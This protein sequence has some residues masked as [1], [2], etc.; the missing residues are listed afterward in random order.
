MADVSEYPRDLIGYADRPVDPRWPGEAKLAIQI[1]INYEEG[2]ENSVLHG[3]TASEAMLAEDP[4][5]PFLGARNIS[6][7]SQYEYGSRAGF[8]R[9]HRMLTERNLP[10]T[11][12]GITT[13]LAKN[14]VA[15][16]AMKSAG[17]EIA[18]HGLKWINY[19]HMPEAEERAQIAESIRLHEEVVGEPPRGWYT[20]R[21]SENTRRLL[22]ELGDF[23]Y[24]SDSFADDLPYWTTENGEP[25][26][27]VPYALDSNDVRYLNGFGLQ[28]PD[29]STYLIRACDLLRREGSVAPKMMS[30]GL[31]CRIA[32]RP[33]RA[34][35]LERFLDHITTLDDVWVTRRIDIAEHWRAHHP[36]IV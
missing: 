14:P 8:W 19:A 9:L 13:A 32:G 20:G 3:D 34:A 29:L 35:D 1:V 26:L 6:V 10:V 23:A 21:M 33:G 11:V 36:P 16:A 31:H 28:A 4:S 12:F 2:G 17:W 15:V 27:V 22:L 25:Q 30:V 24:D 7:E 5:V 18:S